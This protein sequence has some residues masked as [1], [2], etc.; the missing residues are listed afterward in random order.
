MQ[1]RSTGLRLI[2]P[3][4]LLLT[5]G[6]AREFM[7]PALVLSPYRPAAPEAETQACPTPALPRFDQPERDS[8]WIPAWL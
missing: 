8:G 7:P 4:L 1:S 3:L 6:C 2:S 5:L